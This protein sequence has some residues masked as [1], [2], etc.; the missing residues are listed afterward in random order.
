MAPLYLARLDSLVWSRH[1]RDMVIELF[2]FGMLPKA[3]TVIGQ[4]AQII[5]DVPV[6]FTIG[7]HT[8]NFKWDSANRPT[9]PGY[10]WLEVNLT[11]SGAQVSSELVR[12]FVH[13]SE[14]Q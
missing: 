1:S 2:S 11:K 7:N 10:L 5:N 6:S 8:G 9:V 12:V 3:L 4:V 14:A 13:P